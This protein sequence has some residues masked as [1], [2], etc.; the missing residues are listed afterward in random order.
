MGLKDRFQLN[1][2]QSLG[3][4]GA[5]EDAQKAVDFLVERKFPVENLMIVGTNLK[6]VERV[7]APRTWPRVLGRGALSGIGTGFLMGLMLLLFVGGDNPLLML[8]LG[9]AIGVFTGVV[10]AG[11]GRSLAGGK[12]EFE[13]MRDTVATNFEVLVEHKVAQQARE[14]LA[15]MPGYR[16]G[17][18][19]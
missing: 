13:S 3:E 18:F 15:T 1:Y 6:L 12:R 16:S 11:L 4:F 5:Y 10:T 9:L 8:L 19:S 2:P 7:I 14:L 17:L